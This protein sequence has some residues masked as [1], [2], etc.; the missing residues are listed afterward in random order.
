MGRGIAIL[1]GLIIL[2]PLALFLDGIG[3]LIGELIVGLIAGKGAKE[4]ALTAFLSGLI[5]GILLA[6]L[7]FI[8]A[9]FIP[10]HGV[11]IAFFGGWLSIF[12]GIFME[13]NSSH[14]WSN[15]RI[16]SWN[17]TII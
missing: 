9:T 14:R 4:G 1:V 13:S 3:L 5:G 17:T 2:P 8:G 16:N 6:I 7:I 12:L 11:M 15:W 10:H